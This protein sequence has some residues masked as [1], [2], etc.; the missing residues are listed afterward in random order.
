MIMY[1]DNSNLEFLE[2][3]AR[4]AVYLYYTVDKNPINK[5]YLEVKKKEISE[6]SDS[7]IDKW[8]EMLILWMFERAN[9]I[10]ISVE[11]LTD[12]FCNKIDDY[13]KLF[14]QLLIYYDNYG[15]QN[16]A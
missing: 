12:E 11:D 15:S 14:S 8:D 5:Q 3:A 9:E 13:L 10:G 7:S 2:Q 6:T 1:Y 16:L 4:E